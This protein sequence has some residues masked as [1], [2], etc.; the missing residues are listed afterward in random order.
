MGLIVSR[1]N[2]SVSET[3]HICAFIINWMPVCPT[4]GFPEP[5]ALKWASPARHSI[6]RSWRAPSAGPFGASP[7][8]IST[9]IFFVGIRFGAF[10]CCVCGDWARCVHVNTANSVSTA[11][12]LWFHGLTEAAMLL[13]CSHFPVLWET[14]SYATA[15][16]W[17]LFAVDTQ[18]LHLTLLKYLKNLQGT[19]KSTACWAAL[20]QLWVC[21]EAEVKIHGDLVA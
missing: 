17:R 21:Q 10:N 7:L 15:R 13:F 18:N 20:S 14:G 3:I 12:A 9:G 11:L 2:C 4:V 19:L 8:V 5:V 1:W 16:W 6:S